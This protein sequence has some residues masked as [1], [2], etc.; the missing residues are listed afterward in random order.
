MSQISYGRRQLD[1]ALQLGPDIIAPNTFRED[2]N[3]QERLL[4]VKRRGEVSAG[5]RN[6]GLVVISRRLSCLTT[7]RWRSELRRW[8]SISPP[9]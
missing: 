8:L 6:V 2:L 5:R 3:D 7:P 4:D 1:V 9:R